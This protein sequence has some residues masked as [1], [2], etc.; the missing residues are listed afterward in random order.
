MT[1]YFTL[2]VEPTADPDVMELV[3]SH[4][5]AEDGDEVYTSLDDAESGSP[6]AQTLLYGVEGIVALTISGDRLIIT[7]EPGTPWE[8]II[9]EVRDAL[10]DFF[11]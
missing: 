6:I 5:L 11:L 10:R 9:D 7:R 1:E 8:A 3:A 4:V 2:E